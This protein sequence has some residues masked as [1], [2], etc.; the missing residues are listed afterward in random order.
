MAEVVNAR[1]HVLLATIGSS[2]DVHPFV[3]LG[4]RLLARGHRVTLITA[5]YFRPL[6]ESAGLEFVGCTAPGIDYCSVIHNPELW[7]PI[8]GP[9]ALLWLA[10]QP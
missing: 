2:G 8:K 6:A 10:V 3:G 5:E 4:R 9:C 1:R 7:H